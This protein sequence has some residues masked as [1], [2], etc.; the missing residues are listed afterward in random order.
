M[1][2]NLPVLQETQIPTLDQEEPLQ[3]GMATNSNILTWRVPGTEEPD[4]P[5]SM[6]GK[7]SDMTE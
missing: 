4:G 5:Q 7:E 1:V 3:K 6:G 2:K